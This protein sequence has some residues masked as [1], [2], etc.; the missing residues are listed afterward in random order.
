VTISVDDTDLRQ[1]ILPAGSHHDLRHRSRG[2]EAPCDSAR[3]P[4]DPVRDFPIHVDFMRLGE[5]ATIR[6]SVPLHIVNAEV[7]RRE[8][9]RHRQHRHQH[10][11][12]MLGRNIPQFVDADVAA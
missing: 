9:R 11:S 12:G 3:L 4:L 7:R 1:R 5:G 8:A 10:R 6:V 2:Q